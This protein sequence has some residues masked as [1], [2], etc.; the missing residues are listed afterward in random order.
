M[1]FQERVLTYIDRLPADVEVGSMFTVKQTES[2]KAGKRFSSITLPDEPRAREEML[3]NILTEK[4][5]DYFASHTFEFK[6]PK[7]SIKDWKRSLDIEGMLLDIS[8]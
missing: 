8:V 1:I 2:G 5:Y 6:I 7:N 4:I 3:N